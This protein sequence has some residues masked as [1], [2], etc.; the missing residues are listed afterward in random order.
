[1]SRYRRARV[2]GDSSVTKPAL[3]LSTESEAIQA[4][5]T[6]VRIEPI[7]LRRPGP[8]DPVHAFTVDVEDWYQ[9]CVDVDAPITERVVRNVD[10][11]LD[12]LN[13]C[14]VKATFFVQGRVAET[15]PRLVETLVAEGHEVQSHGYSHRPLFSLDRDAL[16]SELKRARATVEDA[17]GARVTAFR[18]QDFSILRDNLWALDVLAEVGFETDS[19]IFP[20]RTKRYGIAGWEVAPHVLRLETGPSLLEVPVAIWASRRWRLPVAGGGYF[21]V[22]PAA[23]LDRGLAA[24][25]I[26]GRP[27]IVYSHPYEFNPTELAEYRGIVPAR[28]LRS[29]GFGRR[30]FVPRVRRLL[31]RQRFGRFDD[32]LRAWGAP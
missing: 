5:A 2:A 1:M 3:T 24:I 25:A 19:S 4:A 18:A 14:G 28:Y 9:S 27:A 11:T 6:G 17:A 29:Q 26:S 22:L 31:T 8:D 13:D 32:V 20:L 12:V 10:R 30:S 15:F 7:T 16:R 23:V 21:R